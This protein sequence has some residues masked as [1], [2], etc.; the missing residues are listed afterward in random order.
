MTVPVKRR[1]KPKAVVQ[2]PAP[3]PRN[4]AALA[5]AG[6]EHD[7]RPTRV[8][9]IFEHQPD[10]TVMLAAG[11]C[12]AVAHQ[13]RLENALGTTSKSFVAFNLGQIERAVR[14]P[15]AKEAQNETAFN[16]ALA[17]IEAIKPQDELEGA[18][19]VQM[20]GCHAAAMDMLGRARHTASTEHLALYS[21]MATKMQ[22]TFTAQLEAL[23]R[24]RGKGQQ[25]VRVE[26][27]TVQAGAQAIVG[28]VHHHPRG[29]DSGGQ[30]KFEEQQYETG[31]PAA[32]AQECQALPSPD[33]ARDGVPISSDAERPVPNPRRTVARR[34]T[35]K[36][37]RP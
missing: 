21:N 2:K 29:R 35:R 13:K 6:A 19:A 24:M 9:I 14:D 25:T 36:S 30:A 27:V 34:A 5:Q 20:V 16:A 8:S 22:R 11:H 18:L 3:G 33:A 1:P 28:D 23:A 12:E 7:A 32:R 37:E 15:Q 17:M 26:H 31:D 4:R 10:G